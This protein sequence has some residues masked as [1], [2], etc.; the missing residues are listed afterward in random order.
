MFA[1]T[2]YETLLRL[3]HYTTSERL[4]YRLICE[5][6][7]RNRCLHNQYVESNGGQFQ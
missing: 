2:P 6:R 1:R 4:R 5:L 3:L 7:S